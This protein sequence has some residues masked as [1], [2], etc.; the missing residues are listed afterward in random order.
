LLVVAAGSLVGTAEVAVSAAYDYHLQSAALKAGAATHGHAHVHGAASAPAACSF[1][2]DQEQTLAT[3][4][5]AAQY[6][7][8]LILGANIVLVTWVTAMRGGRLYATLTAGRVARVPPRMPV[9]YP[10]WERTDV[11]ATSHW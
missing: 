8:R 11:R 9:H 10:R 5:R 2:S 3:D 4:A 1:C 7:A 6:A